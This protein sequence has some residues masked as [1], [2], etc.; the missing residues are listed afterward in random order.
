[1]E[2]RAKIEMDEHPMPPLEITM[3]I[4][5]SIQSFIAI[6]ANRRMHLQ[7]A[8]ELSKQKKQLY[9][10]LREFL[11]QCPSSKLPVSEEGAFLRTN[12]ETDSKPLTQKRLTFLVN[13]FCEENNFLEGENRRLFVYK[14]TSYL[15]RGRIVTQTPSVAHVQPSKSKRIKRERDESGL[16]GLGGGGNGGEWERAV[17]RPFAN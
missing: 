4:Q 13:N 6:E 17:G 15:W 5:Q 3:D 1:M 7:A 14:I 10:K 2:Q 8:Q 12:I 11:L 9:P 16:G